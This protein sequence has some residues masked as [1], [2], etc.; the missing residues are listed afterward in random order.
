[1]KAT[2]RMMLAVAAVL[3]AANAT[4]A[5]CADSWSYD[6]KLRMGGIFKDESG[7]RTTMQETFNVYDGFSLSSIYLNAY[8]DPKTHLLLDLSDINLGDRRGNLEYRQSGLLRFRSRYDES[9]YVFDPAGNV[10]ATRRDWWSSL[11]VTPSKSLWISGDYGLQTRRGDRLGY[12]GDPVGWLGTEYDN[13][14]HRWQLRAQAQQPSNGI[15]GSVTYDGVKQTDA[16][17]PQRERTG[18]VVSGIVHVPGYIFKRLTHVARA[19]IGR[20]ELPNVNNL[21][22]DLKTIQYTGIVDATRW[23]R[24]R[25]QF[26]SSRIDD[27]AT[28]LRTDNIMHDVDATVR[29]RYASLTGGYGWEA[30]D[31]DRSITTANTWRGNVVLHDPKRLVTVRAAYSMRDKDDNESLTLLKDTSYER[32]EASLEARPMK[33]L[34][35]GG[36]V[37]DRTRKMPDIGSRAEGLVATGYAT[38]QGAPTGDEKLITSDVGVDYSFTDDDYTNIWGEEHVVTHAVTGHVGVVL[39]Q[40]IDL[41]AAV[42]FLKMK[43]DLDIEKS[44]LSFAAGYRF[45]RGFLAD[46]QYNVYNF[47]D[48]LVASRYYTANVVWV[49]VGYEFS[50]QRS[51]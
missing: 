4:S 7:D 17:D 28:K 46:V 12:T 18:Y 34:T 45:D 19:S 2:T 33:D 25:Y 1:M 16:I 49:N 24:L 9:R 13:N 51:E 15:G 50:K 42:T 44:I 3:A 48:Y 26:Y 29:C 30:L 10:D 22:Y 6:G 27:E 31:D 43:E 39:D 14:L 20:S 36:R 38:W 41:K 40:N 32:Q 37:A 35:V 5:L 47:D 23:A 11:M 8:R 21:G